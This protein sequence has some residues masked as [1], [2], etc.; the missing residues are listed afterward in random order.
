MNYTINKHISKS[1]IPKKLRKI[2][3][4]HEGDQVSRLCLFFKPPSSNEN[5]IKPS[6]QLTSITKIGKQFI[7]FLT[8][9]M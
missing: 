4:I 1:I 7:Y 2:S 8:N 3:Y 5:V 6:K 9:M